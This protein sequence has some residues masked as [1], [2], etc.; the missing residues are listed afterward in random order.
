M[1]SLPSC[2]WPCWSV[3]RR[4]HSSMPPLRIQACA[5]LLVGFR[6]SEHQRLLSEVTAWI[7]KEMPDGCFAGSKMRCLGVRRT[8]PW[9]LDEARE[10]RGRWL[11]TDIIA[12]NQFRP[13]SL[14][15]SSHRSLTKSTGREF[16]RRAYS[17]IPIL[18]S[19]TSYCKLYSIELSSQSTTYTYK[20]LSQSVVS[21]QV[22]NWYKALDFATPCLFHAGTTPP[23]PCPATALLLAL[24]KKS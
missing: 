20:E 1:H 15:F 17:P 4:H 21:T 6:V 7:L 22:A 13:I 5:V 14:F 10:A 8:D 2:L 23:S 11:M 3:W 19:Y 16:R 9:K 12:L 18:L 24:F